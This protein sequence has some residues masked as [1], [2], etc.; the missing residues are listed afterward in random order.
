[1]SGPRV[2]VAGGHSAGHIEPAM[3]LADAVRRLDPSAEITAVGTER[4]LDTKLIPARGY[5]LELIPPV[6]LPRRPSR[7]LLATPGKLTDAVRAAG[8]VLRRHEI[9]VVVG[10]GGYVAMPV[11]IAARRRDIPIVIHEANARPG[12]ANRLAARLTRHVF[13]ASPA[14]KL[15]HATPIGIPLRPEIAQLDRAG[16]RREARERFGL[17]PDVPTLLVTGGSQG[18]R[19]INAA[20][21]GAAAGLREA[22]VQVLHIIGPQNT[23]D[24]TDGD[25][26][27]VVV[28]YVDQ[29]QIR[30]CRCGLRALPLRRDDLRG[31]DRGGPTRGVRSV[32]PAWRRAALQRRADRARRRW[33]AGLERRPLGPMDSG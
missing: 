20:M 9:E 33:I 25:P 7:A 23:F 10:F 11:Y 13:T 30:L 27:Y 19:A 31:A 24:V 22:G 16:L 26:P 2:L 18:A 8:G 29:M 4:G 1:M 5:P 17:R 6:P 15:P 3:N 21:Q 12:V 28:P 32:A 14:V